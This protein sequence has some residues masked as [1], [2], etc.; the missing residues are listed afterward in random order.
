MSSDSPIFVAGLEDALIREARTA[1]GAAFLSFAEGGGGVKAVTAII[2]A[3][4]AVEA[5]IGI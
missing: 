3:V 5:Q 4:A 2:L 1:A